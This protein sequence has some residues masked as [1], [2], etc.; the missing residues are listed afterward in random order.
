M[1]DYK[2]ISFK[3]A[4][5]QCGIEKNDREMNLIPCNII[6]THCNH[7]EVI[8][9]KSFDKIFRCK[10][11]YHCIYC[12]RIKNVETNLGKTLP[13][14]T[15][16]MN[17]SDSYNCCH[18]FIKININLNRRQ[19]FNNI[20]NNNIMRNNSMPNTN[21][22]QNNNNNNVNY[23]NMLIF[24]N[25]N[26][27]NDVI[28]LEETLKREKEEFEKRNVIEFNNKD[29]II[30]FMDDKSKKSYKVYTKSEMKV[31]DVI[32]DLESQFPELNVKHRKLKCGNRDLNL[33]SQ[34]NS[35]SINESNI[36]LLI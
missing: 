19:D 12:S 17:D 4:C 26:E 30:Y 31:K 20:I 21:N 36:I 15:F 10:I 32:D 27:I 9:I 13:N 5:Q 33:E 8:F 23:N 25:S 2:Y 35:F 3:I 24:D 7:F 22:I 18:G 6:K 34:I 1:Q 11:V 16:I 14:G 28:T 29:K